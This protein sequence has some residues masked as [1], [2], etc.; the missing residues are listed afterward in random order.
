[1]RISIFF[2]LYQMSFWLLKAGK[3]GENRVIIVIHGEVEIINV[4]IY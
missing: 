2:K 3:R 4:F 1:M